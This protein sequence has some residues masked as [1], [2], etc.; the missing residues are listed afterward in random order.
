MEIALETIDGKYRKPEINLERVLDK[1]L[2][3]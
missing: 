2:H 1:K 3:K